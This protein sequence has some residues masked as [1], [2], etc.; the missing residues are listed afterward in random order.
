MTDYS[1]K[2]ELHSVSLTRTVPPTTTPSRVASDG[3]RRTSWVWLAGL[4]IIFSAASDHAGAIETNSG[5]TNGP[6]VVGINGH[7]RVGRMTAIRL[8]PTSSSDVDDQNTQRDQLT[9]ETLD[10]D[11]GKVRYDAYPPLDRPL[12]NAQEIG[13]VVPGSEAAPL[14]IYRD[15]A[16][17]SQQIVATRF[18][19]AGV[20]SRGPSMIPASTPWVVAIGDP[21]GV[22]EIGASNV[23]VDSVARI[24]VTK[25]DS[26][27]SLPFQSLGYD[28]VDLVMINAAGMTVLSEMTTEQTE[29][30][31][32]WLRAGGRVFVCLGESAEEI[33]EV[34]P[35]LIEWLPVDVVSVV[36]YDPAA[37]ET[38]T[39]SQTPL[40]IF[41]GIKLAKGHGQMLLSGRTTRRVSS[42]LAAEYV[43]GFGRATVVVADLE[44]PEFA[45]WPERLELVTQFVGD[46]F[47]RQ[48]GDQDGR[49]RATSFND[50]AGQMRGVLDQFSIK[51]SLGFSVVSVIIMLLIAAIGPLDY[52]LINRFLGKPLLGWMS[53]PLI[54]IGLSVFLVIRAEPRISGDAG[55]SSSLL[56]ANQLQ[57]I[58]IDLVDGVG[59]GFAW[60]YLYS[61]GPASVDVSYSPYHA[62][63]PIKRPDVGPRWMEF[64]MGY[65]GK[66]F[67]GI[68]LA[69]E[70]SQLPAYSI[71]PKMFGQ[72]M[73]G[74][75]GS[76]IKNL[77]IA[78]RSSKSIA[79]Q[80]SFVPQIDGDVSV[81]RRPGSELLRGEFI[82]PLPFDILDGILISGNWVYLL[83]TR[84]P[85]GA[86]VASLEELRQ[87]NFRWRMTRQKSTDQSVT[88]TTRWSPGDFS[89]I[90]RVAEMMMFHRAA[91]GQ[92]Y[93]GL[94]HNLLGKLDLSDILV[95]DRCMLVARTETPLFDLK[96]S[97]AASDSDDSIEPDGNV[98]SVVRVILPL[99]STRLN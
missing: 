97:T 75:I 37:F 40:D 77:T 89:D 52:W 27:A 14:T 92:L 79:S 59:R 83:P 48:T 44:R 32:N 80:V 13:Y 99:R 16:G 88:E 54:A 35:W 3:R 38:F 41:R 68:Q 50:L 87:K 42:V 72:S 78:P 45:Q 64:P 69:A 28:G 46:L 30:L 61:H 65:P 34:A 26:A 22:D 81:A 67:G 19:I 51:S 53:F 85:V 74:P 57:I 6:V 18:P 43:V 93:T 90:Q 56:R 1:Q 60:C 24:A 82:N 70:N 84:V 62:L 29:A 73:Q 66:E 33:S 5:I 49:D 7:Y 12:S 55:D 17:E 10:G 31:S 36:R 71:S 98:L 94:R 4:L 63:D 86:T 91:G 95:D 23:L 15:H 76:T 21:L 25:I 9:I 58:D 47:D 11:G 96:V 20:P 2:P 8:D 39:T